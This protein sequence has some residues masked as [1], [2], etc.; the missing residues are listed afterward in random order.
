MGKLRMIIAD[1]DADYLKSFER[2]LIVNYPHRFELF[3]FSSYISL[4]DFLNGV[5]NIDLL[6]VA[7]QLYQNSMMLESI[8]LILILSEDCSEDNSE[9]N[10]GSNSGI[11]PKTHSKTHSETNPK[12]FSD[13]ALS[14]EDEAKTTA[15]KPG[16]IRKYQHMD[17]FV[18]E[19]MRLYA[20]NSQK[21]L[22]IR[23][24]QG[25]TRIISILSPSGGSGKSTIAAGSSSLC[26]GRGSRT[27]YLNLENIPSTDLFFHGDS[28]QSFSNV[29]F[30]LK[31]KEG[32]LSLRLEGAKSIDAGSNVHYFR[33]PEN[34]Q[35]LN[36]LCCSDINRLLNEL[37]SSGIYDVIFIDTSCGLGKVNTAI[38]EHSDL[39]MLVMDINQ[40]SLLKLKEFAAGLSL[41]ERKGEDKLACKV[42]PVYNRVDKDKPLVEK[43][44]MAGYEGI[45]GR[46]ELPIEISDYSCRGCSDMG[47]GLIAHRGFLSELSAVADC[48]L[49]S[50]ICSPAFGTNDCGGG[51]FIA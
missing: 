20:A 22:T 5:A 41:L 42:I 27:F 36:E 18:G 8:P 6:I 29:I 48:L 47:S 25:N 43:P 38:I 3:S 2:F 51:E 17:R 21:G 37:K 30:H 35:E 28:I 14:Q 7:D 32:N 34:I 11:N 50:T 19:I 45:L 33:P 26:A 49:G 46:C 40:T 23:A 39:I 24:T 16:N 10:S 12:A 1:S 9:S 44:L 4:A 13:C 31:G 15:R